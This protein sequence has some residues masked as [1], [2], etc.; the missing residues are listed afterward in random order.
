MRRKRA[1]LIYIKYRT[2]I[3]FYGEWLKEAQ[4]R[5]RMIALSTLGSFGIPSSTLAR[6]HAP[7]AHTE[8]DFKD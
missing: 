8:A 2:Q 7:Q 3:Y 4:T 6:T 1:S 5:R